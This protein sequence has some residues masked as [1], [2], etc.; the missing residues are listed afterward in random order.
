[1]RSVRR[2]HNRKQFAAAVGEPQDHRRRAAGQVPPAAP[3]RRRRPGDPP[4]DVGAADPD[5]ELARPDGEA[6]ARRDH[7]HAGRPAAL[8]RPAHVRRDV[9]HRGRHGREGGHR[10]R[11]PRHRPA[12]DR[13]VVGELRTDARGAPRQA[14]AAADGPEVHR[15]HRQHLQRRDPLGRG[16]ALGPHERRAHL[17]GGAAALPLDDGDAAGSGEAPRVVAGRR[18]VRRPLRPTRASTSSSTTCT[19]AKDSRARAAGTSSMRERVS[20]RSTFFCSACQ[21]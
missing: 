8:R 21:V 20:G 5:Q 9:R 10:A 6:H 12:R 7:V 16:A 13:D 18:A 17:G 1:M 15:R 4:R 19:P 11:A 2:H 14:E 3:R